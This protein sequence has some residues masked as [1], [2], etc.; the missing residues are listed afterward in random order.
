MIKW[1]ESPREAF[2][3]YTRFIPTQD[4][5]SYLTTLLS[6]GFDALDIGSI[7]S[8]KMVPQ[9]ADTVDV[10]NGLDL[11]GTQTQIIVLAASLKGAAIAASIEKVRYISYP[12]SVSP[13]FQ[14]ININK[15]TE[16]STVL[17]QQ[18]QEI[19]KKNGK[20]L[21]AYVPMAFG[22]PYHDAWDN[23]ILLNHLEILKSNEVRYVS[24][25]NVSVPVKEEVIKAVFSAVIPFF[26][27]I[28][29]GLHLHT[30]QT[31]WF[32]QVEAAYDAGCRRFDTVMSGLGGCPMSNELLG[33]L[34]TDLMIEFMKE[35]E[36]KIP[37]NL[38]VVNHSRVLAA[39]LFLT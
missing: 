27:D 32:G 37:L 13:S 31:N 10:L 11:S 24:L 4:K 15:N 19:C 36:M 23:E 28:D 35:K 2:Q 9:L 16:E 8:P 38:G 6:A 30:N 14:K 21:I 20:T 12:F 22:N 5:I 7:V 3:S 1:I 26:P 39:K 17:L 33:N 18:I 29:T 34:D 25:S